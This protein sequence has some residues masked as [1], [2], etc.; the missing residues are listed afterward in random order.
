MMVLVEHYFQNTY[1]ARFSP[2]AGRL[3]MKYWKAGM[4]SFAI[5]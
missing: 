1:L 2:K 3:P 4:M 5:E